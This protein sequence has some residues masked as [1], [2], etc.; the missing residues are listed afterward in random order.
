MVAGVHHCLRFVHLADCGGS[1]ALGYRLVAAHA[2][3]AAKH[4]EMSDSPVF[5]YER[6]P[7]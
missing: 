4:D 6:N 1:W 3:L 2:I 5:T 7:L